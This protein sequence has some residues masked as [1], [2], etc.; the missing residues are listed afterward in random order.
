MLCLVLLKRHKLIT[1]FVR[2]N[3]S[4]QVVQIFALAVMS[5]LFA[6]TFESCS[7]GAY[8]GVRV[9]FRVDN[10]ATENLLANKYECRVFSEVC[11]YTHHVKKIDTLFLVLTSIG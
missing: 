9:H 6:D 5:S 10:S 8:A 3:T 11:I 1:T 7:N 2:D 4:F